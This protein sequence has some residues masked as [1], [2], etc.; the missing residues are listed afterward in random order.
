VRN[1]VG[2]PICGIDPEEIIDTLPICQEIDR[3]ILNEG[4]VSE[5]RGQ[6]KT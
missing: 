3:Y 5:G 2:N 6:K 4:K 1:T